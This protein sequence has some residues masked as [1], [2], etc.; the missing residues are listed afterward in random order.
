M[1]RTPALCLLLLAGCASAQGEPAQPRPVITRI[2]S[3][4][5]VID[6]LY[7]VK[8]QPGR[9]AV[10]GACHTGDRMPT[11]RSGR[12]DQPRATIPTA[13]A[14]GSLPYIPNA[15]PVTAGPL[16]R[17]SVTVVY[18]RKAQQP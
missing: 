13:P 8:M 3:A 4:A 10:L 14:L 5:Q 6:T 7:A 15:C 11:A 2:S 16:A 18:P 12:L 1:R 9:V 17:K